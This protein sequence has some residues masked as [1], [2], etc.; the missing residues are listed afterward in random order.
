MISG[1]LQPPNEAATFI[2]AWATTDRQFLDPDFHTALEMIT[3]AASISLAKSHWGQ[4]MP[5]VR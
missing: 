5:K 4:H 1:P 2:P 3:Y